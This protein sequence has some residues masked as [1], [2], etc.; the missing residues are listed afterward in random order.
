VLCICHKDDESQ[1]KGEQKQF[2]QVFKRWWWFVSIKHYTNALFILLTHY[3][4]AQSK[5]HEQDNAEMRSHRYTMQWMA[6]YD[7]T[8]YITFV[9]LKWK[10]LPVL[11]LFSDSG[12]LHSYKKVEIQ[13]AACLSK[14]QNTALCNCSPM[15]AKLNSTVLMLQQ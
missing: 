10:L 2:V 9:I 14:I 11:L 3:V 7:G 4:G 6:F 8:L 1:T 13:G 12:I 5:P 15:Q